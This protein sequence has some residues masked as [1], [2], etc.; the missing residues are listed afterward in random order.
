ML[1]AFAIVLHLS[2]PPAAADTPL[3]AFPHPLITE[4]LYA[5]PSGDAGDANADGTRDAA[6][7]EFVEITNPW[8]KAIELGG[9]TLSDRNAEGRGGMRF[10]FPRL[11]VP[12]GAVIVVFNGCKQAFAGPVGDEAGA[13]NATD[14]K[15]GGAAVFTMRNDS[16]AVSLSNGGDYVLLSAPDGTPVHCIKWGEF[17]ETVP[18]AA[19]I[20]DAPKVTGRSVARATRDGPLEAHPKGEH[21]FSPGTLR[22]T[23]ETEPDTKPPKAKRPSS[24]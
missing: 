13:P 15:F 6:G 8:D 11:R 18:A 4:I 7:D 22:W 23:H 9:Y 3:P 1:A 24:R 12:P 2:G 16:G 17:S 10:K 21:P 14:A 19:V 5:V 20:E